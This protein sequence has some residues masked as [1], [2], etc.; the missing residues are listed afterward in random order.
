MVGAVFAV[1]LP[2]AN[3]F[4]QKVLDLSVY[5]TEVIFSPGGDGIVELGGEA[6][7]YLLFLIVSHI[8]SIKASGVDHGLGVM[9]AAE[10]NEKVGYHR[11]LALPH[12]A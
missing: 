12:P 2:L 5:R 7:W 11:C 8:I 3:A 6:Q 9:V 1:F 4:G 10:D